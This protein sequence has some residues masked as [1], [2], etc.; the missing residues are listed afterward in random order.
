MSMIFTGPPAVGKSTLAPAVAAA[1][2]R[3]FVDLDA[4]ITARSGLAPGA[5]FAAHG[6][7][8]F[9]ALEASV[10]LEA[11][12]T[13]GVVVAA[14][15]GT[16]LDRKLRHE[17][18]EKALL[19]GLQ[20]PLDVLAARAAGGARPLLGDDPA[21][22]RLRLE[23]LLDGRS[24][25]YSEVHTTVD[26][27]E[28]AD[29]DSISARLEALLLRDPLLVPAGERSYLV[30]FTRGEASASTDRI[31]ERGP[32][33]VVVV[34]DSHVARAQKKYLSSIFGPL[35]VPQTVVTLAPGEINKTLSAVAAIWDSALGAQ[36]DR[37]T[38]VVAF[39]G[40][41]V[42]DLAGFAAAT[43]LRG[44][45]VV[46]LPTSLLAMVDSSVGGKTGFDHGGGK[47]LIGAFH[48]PAA[49]V[50]D[51]ATLATLPK[52]EWRAGFAEMVKI[53]LTSD[54]ALFEAL[55]NTAFT[56]DFDLRPLLRRAVAAKMR[57]VR[58]DPEERGFR[59]VLNFGHT[60]GHA[61]E[62]HGA[63]GRW[64]HGE[65]VALG[66]LV[67]L[68]SGIRAGVTPGALLPRTEALLA[69][70]GL[71]TAI[72]PQDREQA[73]RHLGHDKKRRGGKVTLP[74][75]VA[76]GEATLE[77]IPLGKLDFLAK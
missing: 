26:V 45:S 37:D 66:C 1:L 21:T 44:V 71:P 11:L 9:R 32:S 3:P 58:D 47:N 27:G 13:P 68:E 23:S 56:E 36:C 35:A 51:V 63:F 72:D 5:F 62:S 48:P 34:T 76:L 31:A 77:R 42:G 43:L 69:R 55:E 40:G 64:L 30:D 52:R 50:A 54:A 2:G 33:Q 29:I 15:G 10:L 25:A 8:A 59:A 22:Q 14:G 49:V 12:E 70:I 7:P 41:V 61:L 65:A 39:G 16:L 28:T 20:A 18:A 38:I 57:V 73:L 53:A 46:Q 17:V 74:R 75:V 67:E 6:E 60:F 24:R 4:A 19:V